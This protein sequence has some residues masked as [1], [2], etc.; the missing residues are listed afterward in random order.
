[1]LWLS[2][3]HFT[4]GATLTYDGF[5]RPPLAPILKGWQNKHWRVVVAYYK[6]RQQLIEAK[7]I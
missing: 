1:M 7:I 2:V 3:K 6:D 4:A 5:L